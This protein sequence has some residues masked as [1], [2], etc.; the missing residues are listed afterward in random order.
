L[1]QGSSSSATVSVGVT[2]P[3]IVFYKNDAALGTLW[4]KALPDPYRIQ[5]PETVEAIPYFISPKQIQHP[6][7]I[8]SWFINDSPIQVSDYQKN[9]LP[10]AAES[11]V[12]GTS[13]LKLQVENQNKIFETASKEI[14]I[15][16]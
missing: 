1:D 5:G 11:G 10:I 13:R 3:K 2:Q 4:E 9:I 7:L 6:W 16:F 8:W 15:E 14:L 12:S